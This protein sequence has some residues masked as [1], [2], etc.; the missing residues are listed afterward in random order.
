MYNHDPLKYKAWKRKIFLYFANYMR[1]PPH[2]A[3]FSPLDLLLCGSRSSRVRH[4]SL[5]ERAIQ[6]ASEHS[7]TALTSLVRASNA[8]KIFTLVDVRVDCAEQARFTRLVSAASQCS[9][10]DCIALFASEQSKGSDKREPHSDSSKKNKGAA[11]P[12]R[13]KDFLFPGLIFQ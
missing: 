13:S 10:R 4:C 9:R 7:K 2:A 6:S 11:A 12:E 5:A 3:P 1:P 8:T